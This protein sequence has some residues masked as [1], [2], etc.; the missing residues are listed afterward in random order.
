M[1][2]GNQHCVY[3]HV[4]RQGSKCNLRDQSRLLQP[5]FNTKRYGYRS[6][7]YFGSKIWNSLP[8]I[9]KNLDDL[10]MFKR[11]LFNWRMTDHD[12]KLLE[13]LEL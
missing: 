7:K 9:I 5:K 11:D 8:T 10:D 6:F 2:E 12:N 13:Q 4:Y 1:H 3:E